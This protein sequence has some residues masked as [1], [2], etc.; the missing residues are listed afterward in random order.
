M[1]RSLVALALACAAT[2]AST[3]A[4]QTFRSEAAVV[5]LQVAVHDRRAALVSGLARDDFR[6][7]EDNVPQSIRFFITDDRPVAV[8]LVVDSS[9]SMWDKQAQ[10]AAAAE[11][12]ARS[13]HPQDALFTVHF[14]E[15]VWL[16]L[17]KDRPFTSDPVV[18]RAL[19][20]GTPARG[21]TAMY[22]G[23]AAALNHVTTSPLEGRVVIV[24]SDGGDN[25]SRTSVD[26]VLRQAGLAN[27]V[28]YM[29][30]IFDEFTSRKDRQTFERL[31]DA[32]GGTAAFPKAAS[33]TRAV[34]ERIARDIRNRYT[35][36]YESTNTRRD[37]AFRS[38]RVEA[39]D[40]AA[41]KPLVARTRA[42]Y[43]AP[44]QK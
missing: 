11:S 23:I 36:G 24:V 39:F 12:F 38:I 22:D 13:G 28:L 18:L 34:L 20:A 1:T 15:R 41:H 21:K 31:A 40:R 26:A 37:G 6:V 16:G 43:H 4:R 19:L 42:G 44:R 33:E 32:T 10:V 7:Y 35:I 5:T 3:G 17:P 9:T 27:A 30:G 8:G 2:S 29:V 25:A 14:N